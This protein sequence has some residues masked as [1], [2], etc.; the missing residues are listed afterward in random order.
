MYLR[1]LCK[2][3]GLLAITLVSI[4]IKSSCEH[5]ALYC[6]HSWILLSFGLGI[7]QKSYT[8]GKQV[9]LRGLGLKNLTEIKD[10]EI[11]S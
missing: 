4:V 2:R 8:G 3:K 1:P 6:P 5:T 10:C 7:E 11:W 9:V